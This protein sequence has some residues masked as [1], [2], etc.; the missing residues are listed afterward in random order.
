M[1]FLSFQTFLLKV[2]GC[3]AHIDIITILMAVLF[4]LDI[5]YSFLSS[6]LFFFLIHWSLFV[7][8]I[9]NQVVTNAF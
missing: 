1:S 3:Y 9:T 7:F 2:I 6:A 4:I 8:Q 5:T